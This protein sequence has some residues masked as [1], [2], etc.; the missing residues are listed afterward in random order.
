VTHFFFFSFSFFFFFFTDQNSDLYFVLH[1]VNQDVLLDYIDL[2][3]LLCN[4][5][6]NPWSFN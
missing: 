5:E 6:E 1:Y 4:S 2:G 3:L